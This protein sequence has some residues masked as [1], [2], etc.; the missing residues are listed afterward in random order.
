MKY[1]RGDLAPFLTWFFGGLAAVC[2]VAAATGLMVAIPGYAPADQSLSQTTVAAAQV[3]VEED[4]EAATDGGVESPVLTALFTE[5]QATQGEEVYTANC[6]ACHGT[7]LEGS[8]GPELAGDAFQTKWQG[9]AVGALYA[10]VHDNM[11]LGAGGSLG[12]D[13]YAN[14]VAYILSQNGLEA[15]DTALPAD[16]NTEAPLDFGVAAAGGAEGDEAAPA[17]ADA[18]PAPAN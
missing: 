4:A 14:V 18:E 3:A 7:N 1:N 12:D 15:G 6:V 8:V 17:D 13:E 5:D 10:Y 11:P 9:E 16:S 2:V